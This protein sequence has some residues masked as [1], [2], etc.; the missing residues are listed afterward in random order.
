MLNRYAT[1]LIVIGAALI[2][3]ATLMV[4]PRETA[5]SIVRESGPI[6]TASWLGYLVAAALA[7]LVGASSARRR[8]GVIGALILLVLAAR[9]LDFHARFTT[10]GVLRLRFWTGS[11]PAISEKFIAGLILTAIALATIWF[12]SRNFHRFKNAIAAREAWALSLAAAIVMLPGVKV[13]DRAVSLVKAW[14]T[15]DVS[16]NLVVMSRTL[17]ET[18][19]LAIPA[20]LI[21]ALVQMLLMR[22]AKPAAAK[23]GAATAKPRHPGDR[24][25]D[26]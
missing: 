22:A 6:E 7:I 12:V 16:D 19:E 4:L 26:R 2:V 23:S 21:A 15:E 17:E 3:A 20:L 24:G 8:D 14:I 1:I 11:E 13:I 18:L 5:A 25:P 10:G 9:E